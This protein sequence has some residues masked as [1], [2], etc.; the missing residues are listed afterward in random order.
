M[1][2]SSLTAFGGQQLGETHPLTPLVVSAVTVLTLTVAFGLLALGIEHF[3]VVFVVGFGGVLPT[4]VGALA[5][6]EARDTDERNQTPEAG[7]ADE[8]ALATLRT[9]Y[10]RGELTD[11]EFEHR[12]EQLLETPD[13]TGN[14]HRQRE[15]ETR[16]AERGR[17]EQS[18]AR[19]KR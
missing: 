16:R 14:G 17:V 5:S 15:S 11:D 18:A 10:A 2:S 8:E 12:V 1:N 7:N 19:G 6:L 9:R 13:T 4:A 3:W